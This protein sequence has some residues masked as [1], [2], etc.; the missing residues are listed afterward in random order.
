MML[1]AAIPLPTALRSLRAA[2][3]LWSAPAP[4]GAIRDTRTLRKNRS[5]IEPILCKVVTRSAPSL[6]AW[7][8]VE[9]IYG[10]IWARPIISAPTELKI[11]PTD[12]IYKVKRRYLSKL[13]K[14]YDVRGR[15]H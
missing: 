11:L 13:A 4:S 9:Y 6:K 5:D 14:L 8:E 12:G 2:A 1:A 15:D 3:A 10:P 7:F